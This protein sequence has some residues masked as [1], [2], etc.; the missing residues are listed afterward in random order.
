MKNLF[1]PNSHYWR[2]EHKDAEPLIGSASVPDRASG[3]SLALASKLAAKEKIATAGKNKKKHTQ[4][5]AWERDARKE[6]QGEKKK[7]EKMTLGVLDVESR[8]R[9]KNVTRSELGGNG[10]VELTEKAP[11]RANAVPAVARNRSK[12]W[13]A[14][15]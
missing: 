4:R 13:L 3:N 15:D 8:E 1:T 2:T 12:P 7:I 14:A 5:V 9:K 10:T 6:R 11:R